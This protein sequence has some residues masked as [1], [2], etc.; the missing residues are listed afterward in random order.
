MLAQPVRQ[1]AASQAARSEIQDDTF[2]I[3]DRGSN[4]RAIQDQECLHRCMSHA[5]V[6][7]DEGMP[8]DQR[9]AQR[10]GLLR[11]RGI[12]ID[13]TEG[14][15]G[16]RDCRLKRAEITEPCGTAGGL[17]ESSVQLDNLRQDQIP[18][19]ARRR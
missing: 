3:L 4:L 15:L 7:V 11:K 9:Q 1:L 6:A 8:L 2:L 10:R 12:Q 13:A 17:E 5:L 14:G 18:H 19:Q 16:L